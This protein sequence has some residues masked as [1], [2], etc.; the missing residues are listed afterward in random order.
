MQLDPYM[1]KPVYWFDIILSFQMIML[2]STNT[3][4]FQRRLL[5]ELIWNKNYA[6]R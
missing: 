2:V 6:T 5:K 3:E 1:S 4:S